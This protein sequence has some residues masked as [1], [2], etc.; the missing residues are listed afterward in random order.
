[1]SAETD[2]NGIAFV[3][4]RRNLFKG[5]ALA[6]AAAVAAIPR[7]GRAA[8][9]NPGFYPGGAFI[10]ARA[11]PGTQGLDPL[12][13]FRWRMAI[14]RVLTGS[15]PAYWLHAAASAAAGV[16]SG[17]D[18]GT[19]GIAGC[20]ARNFI[21]KTAQKLN[22]FMQAQ[23]GT[24][25]AYVRYG[26][27]ADGNGTIFASYGFAGG[28]LA[29]ALASADPR[30]STTGTITGLNGVNGPYGFGGNVLVLAAGATISFTPTTFNGQPINSNAFVVYYE[31]LPA[32]GGSLG[33]LINGAT[34]GV[35]PTSIS[36]T[37]TDA[38]QKATI[39]C[40]RATGNVLKLT[41]A[42]TVPVRLLA[43]I[44]QDTTIPAIHVLN[45]SISGSILANWGQS[46][47]SGT[48]NSP[49]N[50]ISYIAPDLLTMSDYPI[51]DEIAAYPSNF[52]AQVSTD[53]QS[54]IALGLASGSVAYLSPYLCNPSATQGVGI[55][56]PQ[57]TQTAE[58]AIFSNA[59]LSYTTVSPNGI[60]TVIAA[61][62]IPYADSVTKGFLFTDGEHPT[63]VGHDTIAI[64]FS[65]A[66]TNLG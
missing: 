63:A 25:N 52:S 22:G 29:N 34:T 60:P 9:S 39:T 19:Y 41:N 46:E 6:V 16:G 59:T 66:L 54:L 21:Y 32:A 10:Q 35:S 12:S 62:Q 58:A 49:Y 50:F 33:V 45:G 5:A 42:G 43:I 4:R 11:H 13:L 17:T 61:I 15:G 51:N 48:I 28:S 44:D 8:P 31:A 7:M 55:G 36:T 64:G 57:A 47:T 24:A 27:C 56:V 14:S 23:N 65:I 18:S 2:E 1:M 26:F 30:I 38:I 40:T 20:A 37:G 53:F 3:A